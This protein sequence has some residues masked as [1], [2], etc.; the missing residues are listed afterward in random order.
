MHLRSANSDSVSLLI[1]SLYGLK[2]SLECFWLML[3]ILWAKGT[4]WWLH[5]EDHN[6]ELTEDW[7]QL[8]MSNMTLAQACPN[9]KDE[10][11]LYRIKLNMLD[12]HS[13]SSSYL[14]ELHLPFPG[15][16][17]PG[18][19]PAV[20]QSPIG[21]QLQWGRGGFSLTRTFLQSPLLQQSSRS[22]VWPPLFPDDSSHTWFWSL[23]MRL[24]EALQLLPYESIALWCP[25]C[26]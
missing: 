11:A 25:Y 13:H 4:K 8:K 18:M 16:R 9:Y 15:Y 19:L 6:H 12:C 3:L 1:N 20:M 17:H 21:L 5:C 14:C 24:S 7:M 23:L 26:G 2:F 10:Q 22:L